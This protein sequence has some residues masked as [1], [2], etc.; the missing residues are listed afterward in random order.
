MGLARTRTADNHDAFHCDSH[1]R[2]TGTS[3]E[4]DDRDVAVVARERPKIAVVTGED[5][6]AAEPNRR[7]H[8]GGI[9]RVARVEAV[10]THQSAGD[11][12]D[13]VVKGHDAVA[14]TDDSVHSRVATT[15]AVHLG[16]HA[17]WDANERAASR[18]F[19]ERSLCAPG[20]DCALAGRGESTHGLAVEHEEGW[21]RASSAALA[22]ARLV[23]PLHQFERG[24]GFGHEAFVRRAEDLLEIGEQ[25]AEFLAFQL[26]TNRSG[27]EAAQ[28]A[29]ARSALNGVDEVFFH[30][31]GDLSQCHAELSYFTP[32]CNWRPRVSCSRLSFVPVLGAFRHADAVAHL[33]R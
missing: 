5:N 29:G 31:D 16:E 18:R 10:T 3:R 26:V 9:Y 7:R 6:T 8:D 20:R 12:C 25:V 14:P 17:R 23:R 32:T 30:G 28:A 24:G 33:S 2:G 27:D 4:R 19:G 15:A 22:W 21:H 11:A 13:A 1:V